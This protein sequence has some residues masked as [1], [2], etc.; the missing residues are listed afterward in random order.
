MHHAKPVITIC[1]DR[2]VLAMNIVGSM[3][4]GIPRSML[5]FV[6]ADSSRFRMPIIV[7][8]RTIRGNCAVMPFGL[9]LGIMM[10]IVLA[11]GVRAAHMLGIAGCAIY[12][13]V[14]VIHTLNRIIWHGYS[15]IPRRTRRAYLLAYRVACVSDHVPV[16]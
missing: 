4:S 16:A 10:S 7:T 5:L 9:L 3:H 2:R 15:R 11:I 8:I 6:M 14:C 13:G 1:L 12:D